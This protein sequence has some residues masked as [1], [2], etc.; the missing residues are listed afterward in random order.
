MNSGAE[1]LPKNTKFRTK[2]SQLLRTSAKI[3]SQPRSN[4]RELKYTGD[5]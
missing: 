2:R 1:V 5:V 4:A 3:L